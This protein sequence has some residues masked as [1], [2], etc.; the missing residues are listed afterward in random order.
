MVLNPRSS[1]NKKYVS[2]DYSTEDTISSKF[3]DLDNCVDKLEEEMHDQIIHRSDYATEF[4]L[5]AYWMLIIRYE[6]V[7]YLFFSYPIKSSL[8]VI[9]IIF[10]EN[11]LLPGY[12]KLFI[13]PIN[14]HSKFFNF[15]SKN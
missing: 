9:R 1:Y 13:H 3:V 2:V 8:K 10:K 4:I 7:N 11:Y 15:C 12:T 6:T 5:E 14:D